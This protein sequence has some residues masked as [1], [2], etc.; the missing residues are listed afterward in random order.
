[1]MNCLGAS[2]LPVDSDLIS[3]FPYAAVDSR[4]ISGTRAKEK[5][6]CFVRFRSFV[7]VSSNSSSKQENCKNLTA[8]HL[9][10]IGLM[11]PFSVDKAR[12]SCE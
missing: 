2:V 7:N 8:L 10:R 6:D 12:I 5:S 11:T 3:S 4:R 1:M 9:I